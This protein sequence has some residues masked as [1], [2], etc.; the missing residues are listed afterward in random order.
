[1]TALSEAAREQQP[2]RV[3]L[4]LPAA[5]QDS[6]FLAFAVVLSL[7]L[8]VARLGFYSDD[9]VFLSL[10]KN[11]AEQS[12][13][14]LYQAL[15]DGDVVIRQRPVQI[16]WLAVLYRQFGLQPFGYHL[17]NGVV[18]TAG[19]ILFY[20]ALRE[21]RLA[22]LVAVSI[23]LVYALLPHYSTDRFWV[24]A[25]QATASMAFYF[26]SLYADLR[27]ARTGA[28]RLGAWKLLSLASLAASGL[29]YGVAL[30]LFLLNTL[31]AWRAG[32]Q[33]RA[34][35][36]APLPAAADS[37]LYFGSSLFALALVVAFKAAVTVRA[38]LGAGAAD[39]LA[40]LAAGA[41]RVNFGVYGL[42]LPYVIG[43][44]LVHEP[45]WPVLGLGTALG[46][47]VYVYLARLAKQADETWPGR[48]TWLGLAG[49]G[50]GVFA[51]GYAVFVASPDAWFT[52]ASLGNRI[53]IAAA[54]GVAMTLI[55]ILGWTASRLPARDW[56]R[57]LFC[58]GVAVL[59]AAGFTINNTL[60]AF[61]VTAFERHQ[62]LLADIRA[63]VPDWPAGSSLILDGV[64]LEHGG[65]YLFTG[66]RD[67]AAALAL[68]YGEASPRATA[69]TNPPRLAESGLRLFTFRSEDFFPYGPNLYVFDASRK[70]LQALPDAASARRY[71][72]GRSLAPERDC[73]PGFAWGWTSR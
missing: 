57:R 54:V 23:A 40:S 42:G 38:D 43:W 71:F 16:L 24:A 37:A 39:R 53:A 34:E 46:L 50:L 10:L 69:I 28:F 61:W 68:A 19:V 3:A 36:G 60:A 65:A 14:G 45:R 64:C 44:I 29:A 48:S 9:W 41:V 21:L 12:T 47:I 25:H 59:S 7:C 56:R 33:A 49:G 70:S 62:A 51:L 5:G 22:R 2:A 11:S 13:I 72:Q 73:P 15:Y 18:L 32:R 35:R 55:G 27:Q 1:M 31:A 26:L 58:L 20:L 17:A 66:K 4:L 6:L 67:V 30:P 52:S 63:R 8:Y